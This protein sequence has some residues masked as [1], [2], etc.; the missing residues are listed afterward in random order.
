MKWKTL[1]AKI[2]AFLCTGIAVPNAYEWYS[3]SRTI[4]KYIYV[5]VHILVQ[6]VDVESGK[7]CAQKIANQENKLIFIILNENFR[8]EWIKLLV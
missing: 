3:T 6:L 4:S 2:Y 8:P 5:R 7:R 1:V